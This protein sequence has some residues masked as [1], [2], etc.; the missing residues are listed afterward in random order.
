MANQPGVLR[1]LCCATYDVGS[2]E[3]AVFHL[4]DCSAL[5]GWLMA[6]VEIGSMSGMGTCGL[7]G[8]CLAPQWC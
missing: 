6:H 8:A 5:V 1:V 7:D 2:G 3:F 4:A